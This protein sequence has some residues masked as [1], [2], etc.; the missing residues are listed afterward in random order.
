MRPKSATESDESESGESEASEE[1]E[2]ISTDT[3]SLPKGMKSLPTNNGDAPVIPQSTIQFNAVQPNFYQ[4]INNTQ[5]H[6]QIQITLPP[7]DAQK[8]GNC[9]ETAADDDDYDT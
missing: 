5:P 7:N 1:D 4:E 9:Q 3:D 2:D 6:L 8:A